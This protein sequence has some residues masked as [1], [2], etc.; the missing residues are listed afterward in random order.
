MRDGV[1]R[2]SLPAD[3]IFGLSGAPMWSKTLFDRAQLAV[4][5]GARIGVMVGDFRFG[6]SIALQVPPVPR[7]EICDGHIAPSPVPP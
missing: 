1:V 5:D 4:D 2:C 6:N 7:D 3:Q